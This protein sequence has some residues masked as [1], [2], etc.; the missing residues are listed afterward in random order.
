[1]FKMVFD[2]GDEDISHEVYSRAKKH[3]SNAAKSF[4]CPRIRVVTAVWT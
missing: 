2:E 1:M 4:F 3:I